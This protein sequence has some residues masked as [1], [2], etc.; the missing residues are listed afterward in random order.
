[1][2]KKFIPQYEPHIRQSYIDEVTEQ[3]KSGWIGTS[4]KTEEFEELI[5]NIAGRK[6]AVS[7][8][9]GTMAL[10]LGLTALNIP[11]DKKIIFPSYTFLAGAN[12]LASLG[13]E[14]LFIDINPESLCLDGRLVRQYLEHN[15]IDEIGAI[16]FVEHNANINSIDSWEIERLCKMYDIPL[17]IDSAQSLGMPYYFHSSSIFNIFSFSVPK[18]VTTGQGGIVLTDDEEFFFKLKQIRDHGD[19]WRSDKIHKHIGLNL[20]FNDIA[21]AL[22]V[23]QLKRLDQIVK[24]RNEIFDEYKKHINLIDFNFSSTWMVIYKTDYADQI[25]EELKKNEIQAVKYY[26]PIPN[27]PSFNCKTIFPNAEYVY[28]NYLYLPSSL[29]LKNDDINRICNIIKEIENQ[30]V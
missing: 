18:L 22:G 15:P 30:Y 16:I 21:A 4:N 10:F 28:N 20:K 3:I 19:N 9:S 14:I 8:T 7:T 27:N 29:N 12:V 5:K 24:K 11:K 26:R 13:Y 23:A 1:M 2:I 25:I 17:I 6:Y